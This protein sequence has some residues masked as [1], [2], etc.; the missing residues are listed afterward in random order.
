MPSD[1]LGVCFILIL[2]LSYK[3][4]ATASLIFLNCVKVADVRVLL[5][6]GDM[7]AINGGKQ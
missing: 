7:D 5:T 3:N 2:I 6:K 1:C 4:L